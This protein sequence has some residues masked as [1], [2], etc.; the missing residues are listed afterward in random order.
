MFAARLYMCVFAG[1]FH[2]FAAAAIVRDRG[3]GGRFRAVRGR[4]VRLPGGRWRRDLLR[5]R[6][7]H[8]QPGVC[9]RG[10]VEGHLPRHARPFPGQLR[11]AAR[12][13]NFRSCLATFLTLSRPLPVIHAHF[14]PISIAMVGCSHEISCVF[15]IIQSP[16][17][18]EPLL[19]SVLSHS[20]LCHLT[21][22]N[23]SPIWPI[24]CLVG[25]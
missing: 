25:R 3:H 18:V 10:L 23:R 15:A 17:V 7:H 12:C 14:N 21:C 19:P 16:V 8:H 22:K 24:M 6:R 5:P 9:R 11:R 2:A 4:S 13:I 1:C 20:W